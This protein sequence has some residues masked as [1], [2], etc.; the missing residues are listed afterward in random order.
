MAK[1]LDEFKLKL[2]CR[3]FYAFF[4]LFDNLFLVYF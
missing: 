1:S 3:K 2:I 4:R